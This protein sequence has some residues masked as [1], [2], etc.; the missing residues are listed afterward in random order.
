MTVKSPRLI[1]TACIYKA[2]WDRRLWD[3]KGT[4]WQAGKQDPREKPFPLPSV[5]IN[6]QGLAAASCLPP[7]CN[8]VSIPLKQ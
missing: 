5:E 8:L 6:F 2:P 4:G 3:G 7:P 1:C